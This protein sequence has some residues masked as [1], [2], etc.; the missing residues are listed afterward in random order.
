MVEVPFDKVDLLDN[1]EEGESYG[2]VIFI[3]YKGDH[4]HLTIAT[5]EGEKVWVDTNDIWDKNDQ[6]GI[7]ILPEDIHLRKA[8]GNE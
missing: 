5:P 6:V 3:L 4:Y 2:N 1:E 8:E 7:H